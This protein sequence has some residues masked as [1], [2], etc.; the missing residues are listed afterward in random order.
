MAETAIHPF[1]IEVADADL[2]DSPTA[3][4]LVTVAG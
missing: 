4:G 2:E 1:T 3:L